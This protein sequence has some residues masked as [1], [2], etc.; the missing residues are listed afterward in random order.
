MELQ[1]KLE[2]VFGRVLGLAWSQT[3]DNVFTGTPTPT[4][5]QALNWPIMHPVDIICGLYNYQC[6]PNP[7]TLRP[8]DVASMV[9]VYPIGNATPLMAGKQLSH[10]AS[11]SRRLSRRGARRR[12][13][14]VAASP[15]T[16][17]GSL[18]ARSRAVVSTA[19]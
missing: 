11:R 9:L 1:Y 10:M 7:F 15:S 16:M 13:P 3:N 17:R 14:S 12:A 4:H 8:D 18:P 19:T 2:R 6:L 5:N